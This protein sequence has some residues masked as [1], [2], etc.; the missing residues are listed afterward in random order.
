MY[1]HPSPPV[2]PDG[3]RPWTRSWGYGGYEGGPPAHHWVDPGHPSPTRWS[4]ES[5]PDQ[6]SPTFSLFSS[7]SLSGSDDTTNED[8]SS[9]LSEAPDNS[10]DDSNMEDEPMAQTRKAFV[11]DHGRR[12]QTPSPSAKD[13]QIIRDINPTSW[14]SV[15]IQDKTWL[16]VSQSS[17]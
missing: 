2:E 3:A 11:Q 1:M 10:L 15:M 7:R 14:L 13:P 16:S 9:L 8:S 5:S 17:R 6:Q 12:S 4:D